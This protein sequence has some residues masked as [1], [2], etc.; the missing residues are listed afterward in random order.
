MLLLTWLGLLKNRYDMAQ[1]VG[2]LLRAFGVGILWCDVLMHPQ[3]PKCSEQW[4]HSTPG[5][6]YPP[7]VAPHI[8]YKSTKTCTRSPTP[9]TLPTPSL[10]VDLHVA[11]LEMC[12]CTWWRGTRWVCLSSRL[13]HW[14]NLPGPRGRQVSRGANFQH[15]L[16]CC[17]HPNWRRRSLRWS[18]GPNPPLERFAILA[19]SQVHLRDNEIIWYDSISILF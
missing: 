10:L 13:S 5:T 2:E 11:S 16:Q 12:V 3:R 1:E 6:V 7:P 14:K 4:Q 17:H 18:L 19:G 15:Y 8:Y 9:N